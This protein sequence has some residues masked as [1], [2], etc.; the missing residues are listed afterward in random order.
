MSSVTDL[1]E[2]LVCS[3]ACASSLL[4]NSGRVQASPLTG[5]LRHPFVFPR[6]IEEA[7]RYLRYGFA[8]PHILFGGGR[9]TGG[10]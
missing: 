5:P 10:I 4:Q 1:E 6:P 9:T 8:Y 7:Y 2:T 3:T